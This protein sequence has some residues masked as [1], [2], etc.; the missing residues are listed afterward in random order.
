MRSRR[1][2]RR[3]S[4][5][6]DR[7]STTSGGRSSSPRFAATRGHRNKRG[8]GELAIRHG[9]DHLLVQGRPRRSVR[10]RARLSP[11]LIWVLCTR[12]QASLR[13]GHLRPRA[14]RSGLLQIS[15]GALRRQSDRRTTARGTKP[16][17]RTRR[18]AR[19]VVEARPRHRGPRDL[20]VVP[21]RAALAV[22]SDSRWIN[23]V[24]RPRRCPRCSFRRART[25][26]S[27]ASRRSRPADGARG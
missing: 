7:R 6:R 19:P 16:R 20:P 23:D 24:A 12:A 5:R 17:I 26:S 14:L 8:R 10:A 21:A 9:T 18:A 15:R 25:D 22:S 13:R 2:R 4:S 3:R 11:F 1:A 27:A